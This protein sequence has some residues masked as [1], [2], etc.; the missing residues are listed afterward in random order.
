M[1]GK[2]LKMRRLMPARWLAAM[3]TLPDSRAEPASELARETRPRIRTA[4]ALG[5]AG[6]AFLL[7]MK[8]SGVVHDAPL[9]RAIDIAHDIAG[10]AICGAA[11]LATLWR[12]I[13]DRQVLTLA[14]VLELLL[15]ALISTLAVWAGFLHTGHLPGLTWV[16][17]IM[18]LFALMIPAPPRELLLVSA[19]C[20]TTMPLGIAALAAWGQITATASDYWASS[21]AAT[22]GLALAVVAARTLHGVRAEV[23]SAQRMGGYELVRLIDQGGMGE[24]WEARHL[25]LARPSAVKLILPERLQAEGPARAAALERFTREAQITASLRSPHTVQLFD[26]GVTSEGVLYYAME[27]LEGVNLEHF[28]CRHG[29]LAPRRAVYW[30]RQI[31]HSLGEAHAS[32]LTHRD[33][34]PANLLVCTYGREHDV[35][36]VLDFGLARRA[37]A[38]EA[39]RLTR[40]GAWLGTPGWMAPEQIFDGA[41]DARTDLY[42]LGCV[43]YWLLAGERL[44]DGE[45][46]G[47]LLRQHAQSDRVRLSERAKQP[48]PAAL[49]DVVMACVAKDPGARPRD[50]DEV[51][52][53]LAASVPGEPWT[54]ADAGAWWSANGDQR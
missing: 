1:E 38:A 25:M 12:R 27:L 19:A 21:L 50:A 13:P 49:E 35:V 29:P 37:T 32:G 45:E 41:V 5:T 10:F 36:K 16:V 23:A 26:F 33:L 15:A 53:R 14:L 8:W 30:L 47:E 52:A 54:S 48:I 17:P 42:A 51:S 44:F 20:A 4:A 11:L 34:K 40:A 24:V 3:R 31:C 46:Q 28:V 9:D 18:I 39:P 2:G 43:A 6:Y 7:V 22:I